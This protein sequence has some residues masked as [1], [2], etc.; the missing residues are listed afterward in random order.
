M[1]TSVT[2]DSVFWLPSMTEAFTATLPFMATS[3]AAS[4]PASAR[5]EWSLHLDIG[6]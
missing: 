5:R 2:P 6:E 1:L 4:T 3:S